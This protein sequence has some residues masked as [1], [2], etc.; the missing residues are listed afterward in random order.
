MSLSCKKPFMSPSNKQF[1]RKKVIDKDVLKER[2]YNIVENDQYLDEGFIDDAKEKISGAFNSVKNTVQRNV[3]NI[4]NGINSAVNGV[5]NF[6][7]GVADRASN[8]G[9]SVSNFA[10]NIVGSKNVRP[11]RPINPNMMNQNRA[12]NKPRIMSNHF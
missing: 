2:V 7:N 4:T 3:G 5:K 10:T 9:N 1:Y 11:Q 8:I 6:A 12:V